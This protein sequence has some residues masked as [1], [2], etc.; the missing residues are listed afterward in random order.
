MGSAWAGEAPEI[1]EGTRAGLANW[2]SQALVRQPVFAQMMGHG[3]LAFSGMKCICCANSFK[4]KA[5][6]M[7]WSLESS[8]HF[9]DLF[10][11]S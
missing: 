6:F 5:D 9:C 8:Q 10:F 1:Q 2:L 7:S 11:R 4:G 3:C